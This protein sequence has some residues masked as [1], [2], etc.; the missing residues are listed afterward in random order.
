MVSKYKGSVF[1]LLFGLDVSV[2]TTPTN[3]CS[4]LSSVHLVLLTE[5]IPHLLGSFLFLF[6]LLP[7]IFS[8]HFATFEDLH[9]LSFVYCPLMKVLELFMEYKLR[10]LYPFPFRMKW[11]HFPLTRR[12]IRHV[13]DL[14]YSHCNLLDILFSLPASIF[15][16]A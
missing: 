7:Q 13:A 2:P 15:K 12:K 8:K 11:K 9:S 5:I 10:P 6:P 14:S 1:S 3:L 4:R 16:T